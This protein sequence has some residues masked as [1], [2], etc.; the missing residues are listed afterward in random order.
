MESRVERVSLHVVKLDIEAL[1]AYSG[2]GECWELTLWTDDPAASIEEE[3][4]NWA[5]RRNWRVDDLDTIWCLTISR[6]VC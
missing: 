2:R 1:T 4:R 3:V 5:S 6:S